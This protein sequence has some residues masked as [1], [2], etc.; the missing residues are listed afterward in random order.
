MFNVTCKAWNLKYKIHWFPTME[1]KTNITFAT[2]TPDEDRNS[3]RRSLVFLEL[4][5]VM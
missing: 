5:D 3:G 1:L 4:D 2:L